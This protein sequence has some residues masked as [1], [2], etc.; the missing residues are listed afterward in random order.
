MDF[1]GG[2]CGSDTGIRRK[3]KESPTCPPNTML[4]FL[5][6][7]LIALGVAGVVQLAFLG[8]GSSGHDGGPPFLVFVVILVTLSWISKRKIENYEEGDVEAIEKDNRSTDDP[9]R[10]Y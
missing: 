8:I 3:I 7:F 2:A 10:F 5:A 4:R 6:H 1:I 9:F